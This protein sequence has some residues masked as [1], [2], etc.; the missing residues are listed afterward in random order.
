M[1]TVATMKIRLL[2]P[3]LILLS[4]LPACSLSNNHFFQD[5]AECKNNTKKPYLRSTLL[6][7]LKLNTSITIGETKNLKIKLVK[8]DPKREECVLEITDLNRKIKQIGIVKIGG[9]ATIAKEM[10]ANYHIEVTGPFCST[11]CGD[12]VPDSIWLTCDFTNFE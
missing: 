12:Y 10:Q 9:Q 11:T 3:T 8:L 4:C 7:M 1:K 2:L 6:T 5:Q